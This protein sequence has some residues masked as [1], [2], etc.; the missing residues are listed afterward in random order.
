MKI[1]KL[2]DFIESTSKISYILLKTGL[3]LSCL[4]L[5]LSFAL[6]LAYDALTPAGHAAHLLARELFSLPVSVLLISIIG[7]A[8]LEDLAAQRS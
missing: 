3:V 1:Q 8:V 2:I 5:S 4:L 6:F 7:F